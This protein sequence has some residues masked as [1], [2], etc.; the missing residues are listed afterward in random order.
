[1][2]LG[3]NI[4]ETLV[5]QSVFDHISKHR[6]QKLKNEVQ[7]SFPMLIEVFGNMIKH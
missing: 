5:T 3:R 7:P 1:M 2:S 4:Y 6:E